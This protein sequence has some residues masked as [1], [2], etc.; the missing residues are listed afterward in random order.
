MEGHHAIMTDGH[1]GAARI[2]KPAA[3]VCAASPAL[4][5]AVPA[6]TKCLQFLRNNDNSNNSGHQPGLRL[7]EVDTVQSPIPPPPY[8]LR[9]RGGPRY[10]KDT[11]LGGQ[12]V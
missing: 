12:R 7:P 3:I 1:G 6:R 9:Q 4:T 5:G 8:R 2:L 10:S 11:G